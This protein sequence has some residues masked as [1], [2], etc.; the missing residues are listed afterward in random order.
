MKSSPPPASLVLDPTVSEASGKILVS[1][2]HL[3]IT[4]ALRAAALKKG[5]RLLRHHCRL[6][7]IRID[8]EH[9][10]GDI[11]QFVAK[12]RLE[13]SGPDIIA[14]VTCDDAYKSLDLL[15]DRLDRV[16]R[17][18]TRAKADRRNNRPAGTEFRDRLAQTA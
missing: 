12:G 18:R 3:E 9:I 11:A 16:L 14:S 13:I 4:P 10:N 2:I 5:G 1:G 8:L 17:E 7:R 15:V 6:L